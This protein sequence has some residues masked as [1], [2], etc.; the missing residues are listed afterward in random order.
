MAAGLLPVSIIAGSCVEVHF[1]CPAGD[2]PAQTNLLVRRPDEEVLLVISHGG[3]PETAGGWAPMPVDGERCPTNTCP[4]NAEL[5]L[6]FRDV[7][8]YEDEQS[9]AHVYIDAIDV[10]LKVVVANAHYDELDCTREIV[11]MA[12]SP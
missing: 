12:T 10:A 7:L 2:L 9:E 8:L 6:Q 11:W 3:L 4:Q 5:G 1:D